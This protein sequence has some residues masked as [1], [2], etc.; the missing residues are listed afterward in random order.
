MDVLGIGPRGETRHDIELPEQATHNEVGIVLG[1]ELFQAGHDAGQGALHLGD[2]L[3]RIELTLTPETLL[4]L[5]ELFAVE[6]GEERWQARN[7]RPRTSH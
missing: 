2:H 6:I 3:L 1:T 5:E 4:M 7:V